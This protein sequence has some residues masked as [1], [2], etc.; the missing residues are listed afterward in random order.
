MNGQVVVASAVVNPDNANE[1]TVTM[2]DASS[3][4][5]GAYIR[6][7]DSFWIQVKC[8]VMADEDTAQSLPKGAK[9]SIA[10]DVA[11]VDLLERQDL[12]GGAP[13][14]KSKDRVLTLYLDNVKVR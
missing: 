9:L 2:V 12:I 7:A 4:N 11:R 5:G 8:V 6:W 1:Y 10:G 3:R 13:T 14:K